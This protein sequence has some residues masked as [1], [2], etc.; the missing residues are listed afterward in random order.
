VGAIRISEP[1]HDGRDVSVVIQGPIHQID[2]RPSHEA[3]IEVVSSVRKYLPRAEVIVSTW[4]GEDVGGLGA[5]VIVASPDP[6]AVPLNDGNFFHR[7]NN[8]NRQ[9]VSTN[10]GLRASSRRFAVKLRTDTSIFKPIPF[11]ELLRPVSDSR[12]R[13]FRCRIGVL[14]VYTRNP[15]KRPVLFHLGDIMQFGLTDDIRL[16]W[17]VCLVDEPNFTRCWEGR[18]LPDVDAYPGDC[19][20][21]RCAPEQY[22]GEQLSLRCVESLLLAHP[23]DGDLRRLREWLHILASNFSILAPDVAGVLLPRRMQEHVH[24][25]DLFHSSDER[26]LKLWEKPR[27]SAC[28]YLL[29]AF[30]FA[31]CRY[32]FRRPT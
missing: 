17:D 11:S 14:N 15:L 2:G 18:E 31:A 1:D 12:W 19:Y 23:A 22:L 20:L 25:F 8:L 26:W 13:I 27:V 9:I 4:E 30:R 24:H 29:A 32:R 7:F 21:F 3:T 28:M 16:L 5:D 10:A 6:G